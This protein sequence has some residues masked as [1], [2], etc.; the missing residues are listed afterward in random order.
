[1]KRISKKNV[2]SCVARSFT[3]YQSSERAPPRVEKHEMESPFPL[4]TSFFRGPPLSAERRVEL[5]QEAREN[6]R[7]L[8]R[9]AFAEKWR[10]IPPEKDGAQYCKDTSNME[11]SYR[12]VRSS[13]T[14]RS[15]DFELRRILS[16]TATDSFRTFMRKLLSKN[17]VDMMV[18]HKVLEN[19]EEPAD[20]EDDLTEPSL[21][22]ELYEDAVEYVKEQ[23]VS[24]RDLLKKI[25]LAELHM[26]CFV[27]SDGCDDLMLEDGEIDFPTSI[28]YTPKQAKIA[29]LRILS[30]G[31]LDWSPQA[32]T[33][34]KYPVAQDSNEAVTVKWGVLESGVSNKRDL[35]LLDHVS[36]MEIEDDKE[37][38]VGLWTLKSIEGHRVG[39]MSLKDSH[40]VSRTEL[41]RLGLFW[42][43]TGPGELE[44]VV[45]GTIKSKYA[46][47]MMTSI[48]TAFSR[49]EDMIQ[50]ARI[51]C[52]KFV[53]R[54]QWVKDKERNGC[55]LC[56]R[57][58]RSWRRKHHC[59]MCGE[60][61]CSECSV[62]RSVELPVVGQ[63][64]LR[65][66]KACI[67]TAKNT[68]MPRNAV[69]SNAKLQDRAAL[70]KKMS[71][72]TS[73]TSPSS[74][75]SSD[76]VEFTLRTS[77]CASNNSRFEDP[78]EL[79][80]ALSGGLKSIFDSLCELACQSLECPL[81]LVSMES[82][83]TEYLK[84]GSGLNERLVKRQ[85][86]EFA[87]YAMAGTPLVVLDA[88]T[89][90]RVQSVSTIAPKIRFF[91]GCPIKSADGYGYICVADTEKR[92]SLGRDN[93][94]TMERLAT[95]ALSA[96]VDRQE[97]TLAASGPNGRRSEINE[98]CAVKPS[99]RA[100]SMSEP[101]DNDFRPL[102]EAEAK[103]RTLLWKSY[104]TQQRVAQVN[105][106]RHP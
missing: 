88:W 18:L 102:A 87:E 79:K 40:R 17:Y 11:E 83:Q 4:R 65:L 67:S 95:L 41:Q 25:N 2:R 21:L 31:V 61:V 13:I 68:P 104:E 44:V 15:T 77:Y 28:Q 86:R 71:S 43:S 75:V 5:V 49:L 3:F 81:A 55:N 98:K 69:I 32:A 24:D 97:S 39:C 105:S 1:M 9:L 80:T 45:C 34:F 46:K 35:C 74:S 73:L 10:Y 89:D 33:I 100:G 58:F 82:E 66:C 57:N 37:R 91:A 101:S 85:L 8:G 14:I 26:L 7:T 48:M 29:F 60:V 72:Q 42:R 36:E 47:S 103:M 30:A 6:S 54:D 96:M 19:Q 64:K 50:D 12:L 70:L 106:P 51:G 59:R 92:S 16:H 63:S 99:S 20:V 52:H 78:K 84:P 38:N 27:A 93:I 22:M 56:M 23:I 62:L 94:F 53:M 76:P 90:K